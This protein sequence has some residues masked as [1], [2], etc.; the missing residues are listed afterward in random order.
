MCVAPV[1]LQL[2][3]SQAGSP[4]QSDYLGETYAVGNGKELALYGLGLDNLGTPLCEFDRVVAKVT[5]HGQSNPT[6][7]AHR[8]NIRSGMRA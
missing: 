7:Y 4:L 6:R 3:L 5:V 1:A 2:K 8:K